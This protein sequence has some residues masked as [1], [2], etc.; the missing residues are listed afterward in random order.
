[1]DEA[2]KSCGENSG[3]CGCADS[4]IKW[5]ILVALPKFMQKKA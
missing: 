1:M 5:C 4:C 3:I 2:G